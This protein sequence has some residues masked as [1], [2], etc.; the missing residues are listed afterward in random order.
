MGNEVLLEKIESHFFVLCIII[1]VFNGKECITRWEKGKWWWLLTK[2]VLQGFYIKD[3]VR[4]MELYHLI[5]FLYHFLICGF[6][7]NM[8]EQN[9]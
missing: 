3:F 7:M 2:K 4:I 8:S 6:T 1:F 5:L 9:V